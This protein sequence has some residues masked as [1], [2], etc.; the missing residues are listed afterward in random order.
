MP[1][2]KVM[3]GDLGQGRL[4]DTEDEMDHEV[5]FGR[6]VYKYS[7][8]PFRTG[9]FSTIH[10]ATAQDGKQRLLKIAKN[11]SCNDALQRELRIIRFYQTEDK[12]RPVGRYFPAIKDT[13]TV[14]GRLV[15]VM[16]YIPDALSVETVVGAYDG[17]MDPQDAAWI[18]RRVVAQVIAAEM[19]ELVHGSILPPHVLVNRVSHNPLHIGWAHAVDPRR[20]RISTIVTAYRD[21]YPP[22]VF[23]HRR[24]DRRTDIYMAGKVIAYTM[25]ADPSTSDLPHVVPARMA[26]VIDSCTQE[27]PD[28]RYQ[29][30]GDAMEE[31][32]NA[33]R[34]L[35]GEEYR[36]LEA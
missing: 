12:L 30:G 16:R 32:T 13:F 23:E 2:R 14:D 17:V 31:L 25:G 1:K 10:R 11:A 8:K 36:E 15:I 4:L 6:R 35:W 27:D 3:F 29:R 34:E 26:D 19:G 7:S 33:V 24:P 18:A 21:F 20:E 5:R 22:E 9:E 28:K